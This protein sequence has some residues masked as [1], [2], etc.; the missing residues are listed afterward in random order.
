MRT[1]ARKDFYD[2]KG[3]G[4]LPSNKDAE[5]P[6]VPHTA[7]PYKQPKHKK[8]WRQILMVLLVV[9]VLAGLGGGTYWFT[10]HHKSVAPKS[11]TT[12]ATI[13]PVTTSS[14]GT[15]QYV[16]NGSD[17]NLSFS[18]PS[19]W[20]VTPA[21]GGNSSDQTITLT[22]PLTSIPA[23]GG[24]TVTGKVVVTIRPGATTTPSE[25][26]AN[27]PTAAAASAQFA[28][29]SPTA[30]QY[31]YPYLTFI[32]FSTGVTTAGAFEE[33]LITGT[34]QF[35]AGE[36]VTASDLS[37]LDPI[38]A[39]TFSKCTTQA[40][41]ASGATPLSITSGTWTNT[42]VFQQVQALFTSMKLN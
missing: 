19:T 5:H 11:T 10:K 7:R 12:Q 38:I 33:V 29:S 9:V 21:S 18:Y 41:T 34:T 20:T 37:G 2:I 40:C 30:N 36:A 6:T 35:T 27:S 3:L 31:Q 23:A 13:K 26:N 15:A 8:I 22:S 42:S 28:Y 16:S 25:L 24:S 1:M 4:E 14:S 32:H 17:L 39:A